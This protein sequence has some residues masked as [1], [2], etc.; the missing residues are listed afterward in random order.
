MDFRTKRDNQ[1]FGVRATALIIKDGKILLAK[2]QDS[3]HTIGG[4]IE[5]NEKTADAVLRETKE[6]L[7]IVA[8]VNHLA[9]VVENYFSVGEVDF[10]NVEFHYIVAPVGEVPQ[11]MTEASHS[12]PCDWLPIEDLDKY[13]VRPDFLKTELKNWDEQVKHIIVE[14][15]GN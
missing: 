15:G 2:H 8:K 1:V 13:D 5:V 4:A 14:D 10:H 7:G 3:Y 9:F 11:V 12:Y 6:E